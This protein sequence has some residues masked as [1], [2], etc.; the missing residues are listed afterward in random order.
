MNFQNPQINESDLKE[1][2]TVDAYVGLSTQVYEAIHDLAA[3]NDEITSFSFNLINFNL[4]LYS[5]LYR[6]LYRELE[7]NNMLP[8]ALIIDDKGF[9]EPDVRTKQLTPLEQFVF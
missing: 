2:I 9:I 8:M 6:A 4:I 3:T 5:S 7:N 1:I